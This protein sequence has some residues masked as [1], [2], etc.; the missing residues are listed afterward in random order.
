MLQRA[1]QVRLLRRA[2]RSFIMRRI[3]VALL[4]SNGITSSGGGTVSGRQSRPVAVAGDWYN[5][6]L[7]NRVK[8]STRC[9][10][11]AGLDGL[12]ATKPERTDVPMVRQF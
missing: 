3:A 10:P 4:G 7:A 8:E 11:G 1:T 12:A 6:A 5:L 9:E 2:S